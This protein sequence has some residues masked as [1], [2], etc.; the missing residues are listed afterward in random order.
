MLGTLLDDLAAE[1]PMAE[2]AAT[3][4]AKMDPLQYQRPQ[5]APAAGNL[6]QAERIVE[7][8]GL[9][10]ALAR[11]FARL[12]DIA[13][14]A[15][16][17]PEAK[18]AKPAEGGVFAHLTP[19]DGKAAKSP[20]DLPATTMTWVK[21]CATVLPKARH[22]E[23]R[24]PSG[25]ASWYA[26]VTAEDPAAPP[27]LQWDHPDRRNPVSVFTYVGG[28]EAARWRLRAGTYAVVTAIALRP[29]Q[30]FGGDFPHQGKSAF[31]LIEGAR[32]TQYD[33]G[34]LFFPEVLRGELHE[35]RATLEAYAKN[36]VLSGRDEAT[37]CGIEFAG[38]T[39]RVTHEDGSRR[40][41]TLDRW[42]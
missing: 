16:R 14:A 12:S 19:K 5:A 31:F 3:W 34:A 27:I 9:A 30:W 25:R 20:F 28:T 24:V 38:Q 8:L 2:I 42:D 39:F 36:G 1:K 22:I 40:E 32:D 37:A 33:R 26:F 10:P 13:D 7:K 23:L 11:R 17:R 18:A 21:L 6:A 41:Y 15:W 35:V 29:H 4:K